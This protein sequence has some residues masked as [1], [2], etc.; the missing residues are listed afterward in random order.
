HRFTY[1][2]WRITMLTRPFATTLAAL[3][4]CMAVSSAS[5]GATINYTETWATTGSQATDNGQTFANYPDW[6]YYEELDRVSFATV[7]TAG[8]LELRGVP[9]ATIAGLVSATAISG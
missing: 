5:F 1:D 8:S 2:S 7:A 9:S 6:T 4:S 3:T